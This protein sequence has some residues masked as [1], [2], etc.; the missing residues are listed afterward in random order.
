[1]SRHRT[2]RRRYGR[3]LGREVSVEERAQETEF[4][5]RQNNPHVDKRYVAP[6][7]YVLYHHQLGEIGSKTNIRRRGKIV[8]VLYI[9]PPIKTG[10]W[11]K[12]E[13]NA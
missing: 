12:E 13:H 9:L 7:T 8:S 3:A 11:E 6:D 4:S 2:L 10:W 1:M 5:R